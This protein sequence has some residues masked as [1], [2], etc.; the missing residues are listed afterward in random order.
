[1]KQKRLA[2]CS[3]M[4]VI[5]VLH[6]WSAIPI[7]AQSTNLYLVQP[8]D[9]LFSISR[10]YGINVY[11]LAA[12]NSLPWNAWI[13]TGQRLT[14]PGVNLSPSPAPAPPA[15][16]NIYVVNVG[17]TL[18]GIAMRHGI[19]A[20]QL[21]SAN[22]LSWNSWV[23]AGQRLVIP[24]TNV[25]TP[26]PVTP[27][28]GTYIVKAG[29]TLFSIARLYGTTVTTLKTVNGLTSNYI[30]VGQSLKIP[31][32]GDPV[33][34]PAA[35]T[36]VPAPSYGGSGKWIDVNLSSQTLTAYEG[37]TPVFTAIVSTGTWQYPTV[38]GTY[39]VYA[40][41]ASTRMTGGSGAS[42][43]DLPNVPYTM[44]FY[45]G[46]AIHGTYWHNNFGTPM[47]HGCVNLTIPDS[48]WV[49][50]WSPIGTKVVTHY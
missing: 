1:M 44:Y 36:P 38:T 3:L 19:S 9:T 33:S 23:Y 5:V 32:A 25:T 39:Q 24:G 35:A 2:L 14:I 29:N 34:P 50:N 27:T 21:A 11:D 47:S 18:L 45:R 43:Y 13:Y 22:G 8:G 10:R 41:Y 16:G 17:D 30:Y 15:T 20:S 6:F 46:Y 37:Q 40:K 48:E 31:G 28:N 42:Y 7:R 26:P 4:I 12:A 49:Y